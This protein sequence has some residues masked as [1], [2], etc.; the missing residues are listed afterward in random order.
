LDDAVEVRACGVCL[1]DGATCQ[2]EDVVAVVDNVGVEFGYSLVCPVSA[3]H[4]EHVAEG[5]GLGDCA[6]DVGDD[7][8]HVVLPVEHV[9]FAF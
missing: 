3:D 8:G 1:A 4:V 6:V 2:V 5:V 7:D 9:G